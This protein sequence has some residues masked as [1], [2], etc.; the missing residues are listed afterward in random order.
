MSPMTLRI[1][2]RAGDESVYARYSSFSVEN[3]KKH[4]TIRVSGY[5]GTA[6]ESLNV[7]IDELAR[8]EEA[9]EM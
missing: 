4:Y 5:S 9:V 7:H 2:L 1:D 6:G 3:A 8:T